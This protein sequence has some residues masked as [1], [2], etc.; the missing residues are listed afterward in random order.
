MQKQT[1]L[2]S[3]IMPAY[4]A[5]PFIEKSIASVLAQTVRD[6]EL[7]VLDDHSSDGTAELVTS[8]AEEDERIRLVRN[9]RNMGTAA[10]RN[11]GLELSRGL[12]VALLDSDDVWYPR[13]LEKQLQRIQSEDA[14]LCYCAYAM[15]SEQGEKCCEDFLVRPQVGLEE[16][17]SK[18]DIGCSTV[19]LNRK[20]A[21]KYRFDARYYHEDYALWLTMLRD[22][23]KAVGVTEVLTD[24]LVRDNSRASN[25]LAG[26]KRRWQIYRKMMG[27][28]LW[29][30]GYYSAQY[31]FA[32]LKKYRK[33]K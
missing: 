7:I 16:L 23:C 9:E 10:T 14:Q 6:W 18:N 22:G 30:S 20:A 27:F 31:A 25:K 1:P 15:V 17:L 12:F 8:L 24:Y 26:A 11:R 28:S 33:A 4:N 13:K 29:R 19:M 5:E 2:V 32:G 3:V 21:D